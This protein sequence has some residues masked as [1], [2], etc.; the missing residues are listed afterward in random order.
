MSSTLAP[1]ISTPL[2]PGIFSGRRSS[3]VLGKGTFGGLSISS[4]GPSGPIKSGAPGSR[5][6]PA[7]GLRFRDQCLAFPFY[8][9]NFTAA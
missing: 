8:G 3:Q 7:G 1:G 2:A 5:C 6:G 9:F 4:W